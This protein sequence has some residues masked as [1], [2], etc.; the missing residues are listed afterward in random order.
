MSTLAIEVFNTELRKDQEA[1]FMT[2]EHKKHTVEMTLIN[3]IND[4]VVVSEALVDPEGKFLSSALATNDLVKDKYIKE[5]D[6]EIKAKIKRVH[7][8]F[9]FRNNTSQYIRDKI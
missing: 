3:N 4:D 1:L 2:L 9:L 8:L 6:S 7:T 5:L